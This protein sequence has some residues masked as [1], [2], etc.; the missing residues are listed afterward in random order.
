MTDFV[1]IDCMESV[2]IPLILGRPFLATSGALIDAKAGRLT[3][4]D[5]EKVIIF[6]IP[7]PDPNVHSSAKKS[8]SLV[9]E[10]ASV[11]TVFTDM[12]PPDSTSSLQDQVAAMVSIQ[13]TGGVKKKNKPPKKA[14]APPHESTPTKPPDVV[15]DKA[16][17]FG[18]FEIAGLRGD[19]AL[20]LFHASGKK[21][22]LQS[23]A[24]K[25]FFQD[26]DASLKEVLSWDAAR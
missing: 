15:L 17:L 2:N 4:R 8:M 24:M 20:E 19:G 10:N 1:V 6:E 14:K 7:P 12:D 11:Y 5:K 21:F 26:T 18:P 16:E 9:F 23:G 22:V 13:D 25:V 3:F